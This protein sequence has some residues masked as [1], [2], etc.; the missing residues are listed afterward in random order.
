MTIKA[1]KGIGK[2]FLKASRAKAAEKMKKLDKRDIARFQGVYK[3]HVKELRRV[4]RK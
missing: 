2:A 3:K 4:T 1:I